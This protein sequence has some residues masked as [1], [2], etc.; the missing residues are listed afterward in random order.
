MKQYKI[1]VSAL[2]IDNR[3]YNDNYNEGACLVTYSGTICRTAL[4]KR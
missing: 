2:D 4:L 1:K 3:I